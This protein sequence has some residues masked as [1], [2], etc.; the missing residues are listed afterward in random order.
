[1]HTSWYL[2]FK[3]DYKKMKYKCPKCKGKGWVC[4]AIAPMATICTLGVLTALDLIIS[5][6][7]KDSVIRKE[8]NLCNGEGYIDGGKFF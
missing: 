8:C 4:S 1:M 2:T 5:A 3:Q 7:D 6:G